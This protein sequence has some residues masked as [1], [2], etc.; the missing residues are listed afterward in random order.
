LRNT[1]PSNNLS[2][3]QLSGP[4]EMLKWVRRWFASQKLLL[5]DDNESYAIAGESGIY[6]S[7]PQHVGRNV[8]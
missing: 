3:K 2:A 6:G 7:S 1:S 5:I 8:S 4:F